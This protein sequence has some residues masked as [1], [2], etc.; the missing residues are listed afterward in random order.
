MLISTS[1]TEISLQVYDSNQ[2]RLAIES[3]HI[4][5]RSAECGIFY[6]IFWPPRHCHITYN[7]QQSTAMSSIVDVSKNL[8]GLKSNL[9][10][11]N[12]TWHPIIQR[13]FSVSIDVDVKLTKLVKWWKKIQYLETRDDSKMFSRVKSMSNKL[14]IF[15]ES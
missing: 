13:G 6:R 14:P 3:A 10:S 2:Q 11:Y 7:C 12:A 8:I 4:R 9:A 15:F 5:V 1:H